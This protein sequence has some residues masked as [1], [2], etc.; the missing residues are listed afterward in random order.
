MVQPST[1]IETESLP[2]HVLVSLCNVASA[3]PTLVTLEVASSRIRVL[4]VPDRWSLLGGL[5]GLAPSGPYLYAMTS[6]STAAGPG[7]GQPPSPSLLLIFDRRD[8]R[9]LNEY[10]CSSVFDA[11]SLWATEGELYVVSTGTD[12]VVR[13]GL[14]EAEVRREQVYWRPE[15]D[16]PTADV[17]H[18]NAIFPWTGDLLVSG[19]GRKTGPEWSSACEGFV[20][21]TRTGERIASGVRHPHSLLEVGGMLAYCESSSMALRFAGS[22]RCQKLPGYA[23]GLCRIGNDVFVATSRGRRVS[24]STGALTTLHDTGEELAGRCSIAR[25]SADALAIADVIELGPYGAEVYDLLPVTD[26]ESWPVSDE[27]AW[28]DAALRGLRVNF[29]ERGA[30]ISSLH[31]EVVHRDRAVAWLHEEVAKRD[32]TIAWLH[33]EVAKGDRRLHEEVAK[34]D[35]TIA[36]LHEEVAKRDRTIAWLHGEVAARDQTIA[37]GRNERSGDEGK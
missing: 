13:I 12:S 28:H 17:H 36:W 21:N 14:E 35:Q 8:L 2:T 18:L 33:E 11:H 34:L 25:L 10:C 3:G 20:V 15:P 19:F 5:T 37:G 7:S 9:L 27:L 32:Q 29:D 4:D 23:R 24:K 6:R 30:T 26:V 22:P 16:G 1:A 31:I